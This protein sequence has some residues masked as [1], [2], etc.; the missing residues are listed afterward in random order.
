M[1]VMLRLLLAIALDSVNYEA[2][3]ERMLFL[4]L[5]GKIMDPVRGG[6]GIIVSRTEPLFFTAPLCIQVTLV[7][8]NR[9]CVQDVSLW[10]RGALLLKGEV[11]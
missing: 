6:G 1:R 2:D 11:R 9:N 8:R 4:D 7:E 5:P 3:L 10:I